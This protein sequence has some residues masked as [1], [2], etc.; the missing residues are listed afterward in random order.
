MIIG[1]G[2]LGLANVA[3]GLYAIG[4]GVTNNY[5]PFNERYDVSTD[6]WTPFEIPVNRAGIWKNTAVASMLTEFYVLGGV[7]GPESRNDNFVFEVLTNR[8]FL[9]QLQKNVKQ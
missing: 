3:G 6:R 2:G 8:S 4:G 7:S 5:V 1:R 9:P